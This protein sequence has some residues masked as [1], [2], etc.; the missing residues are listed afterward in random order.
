MTPESNAY[1][2]PRFDPGIIDHMQCF[3]GNDDLQ[4]FQFGESGEIGELNGVNGAVGL[5][6]SILAAVVGEN[7]QASLSPI[8][9]QSQTPPSLITSPDLSDFIITPPVHTQNVHNGIG[10]HQPAALLLPLSPSP[11]EIHKDGLSFPSLQIQ[12]NVPYRPP[13][14][15]HNDGLSL[16]RQ[17]IVPHLPPGQVHNDG[18]S[19]QH[20]NIVPH[21]PPGQVHND[22]LSLQH[23]NI[24]PYVPPGQVHN[25]GPSLPF[26]QVRSDS[27]IFYDP[28][29]PNKH[30]PRENIRRTPVELKQQRVD[31]A[32]LKKVGG[33]CVWCY[34]GKKKCDTAKPCGFCRSKNR[35]CYRNSTNLEL[36]GLSKESPSCAYGFPS[37]EAMNTLQRMA[38]EAFELFNTINAVVNICEITAWHWTATRAGITLSRPTESHFLDFLAGIGSSVPQVNL[39]DF[40]NLY[41]DDQLVQDALNLAHIFMA[42]RGLA[43]ARIRTSWNEIIPGRLIL[44]YILVRCSEKLVNASEDFCTALYDTLCGK[45]KQAGGK[46]DK[47]EHKLDSTWVA[48]ALYYRVVCGLQDLRNNAVVAKIFG[49]CELSLVRQRFKDIL[50]NVS[51][52]SGALRVT[53]RLQILEDKIPALPSS[54]EVDIAFWVAQGHQGQTSSPPISHDNTFSSPGEHMQKFLADNFDRPQA[55]SL[56]VHN[57]LS[58]ASPGVTVPLQER[59]AFGEMGILDQGT[60]FDQAA[61][62]EPVMLLDLFNRRYDGNISDQMSSGCAGEASSAG[63][64]QNPSYVYNY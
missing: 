22:G 23:Q 57:G 54:S 33:T 19:L 26:V 38:N 18:L 27:Y 21:L 24:V 16:Q 36:T 20:Q 13:G 4:S 14:Q 35:L 11:D 43:Q 60:T 9:P 48:A 64:V 29:N 41:R 39:V 51:P 30:D 3:V 5:Q 44:F 47:L 46:S 1:E 8:P 17:N 62:S 58:S 56:G 40:E 45:G 2:S 53:T 37:Q 32:A 61:N 31:T 42:L 7:L 50:R 34:R 15:V 49:S 12:N 59:L 52:K 25:D 55:A 28:N 10:T 63:E 6:D